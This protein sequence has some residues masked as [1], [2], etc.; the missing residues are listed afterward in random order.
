M[1]S[2]HRFLAGVKLK[3]ELLE[4]LDKLEIHIENLHCPIVF[5]HNDLLPKNI[6][7]SENKGETI[8]L[9]SFGFV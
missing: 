9:V 7:L 2:Y 5:S 3:S 1:F 6:I 8:P 4:E